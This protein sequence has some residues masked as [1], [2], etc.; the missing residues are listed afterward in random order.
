MLFIEAIKKIISS[1]SK[2]ISGFV[3]I[4]ITVVFVRRRKPR[5]QYPKNVVIHHQVG[6]GP[7]APSIM[8]FAVKLETYLRMNN[9]PYLNVHDSYQRRSSKGKLT[10]IEYNGM[11]V[12]DSEFSIKFINKA[13]DVDPDKH[14]TEEEKAMA[15]AMQI[16]VEEHTYWAVTF[17]RWVYERAEKINTYLGIPGLLRYFLVQ[18]LTKKTKA[19][20]LGLHSPS[21]VYSIMVDDLRSLA[22]F[23]GN[24]R[25]LMGE[26]PCKAD[27]AIFGLLSQMYWL[28]FGGENERA[29]KEFPCL[30]DYCERMKS[31]FWPD[32]DDCI[33]HGG[34]KTASN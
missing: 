11:K 31:T 6:R 26:E 16:M 2:E 15:Y 22:T 9:V 4:C 8:P 27:C 30:C 24:K 34:T 28:S 19:Q 10:W 32:W 17:F 7:F 20:G 14:L 3:I 23:L 12:A 1:H 29:I 33:T 18:G 25:F 13:F 21:E 5:K